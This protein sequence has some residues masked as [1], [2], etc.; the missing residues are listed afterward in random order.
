MKPLRLIVCLLV[1]ASLAFIIMRSGQ[2][3]V[4]A[5]T[6]RQPGPT[7]IY[8]VKFL[9]GYQ[10]PLSDRLEPPVKPGNYAT[11]INIHN[12][13]QEL[14]AGLLKRVLVLLGTDTSGRPLITREPA[15][16]TPVTGT[17]Q[18]VLPP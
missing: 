5:T 6:A 15:I 2:Q 18:L 17:E 16:T 7:L 10:K 9:C 13:H 4:T 8:S 12:Y 3:P 14:R 11:E 1:V